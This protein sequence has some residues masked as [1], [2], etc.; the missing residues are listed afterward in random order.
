M[1]STPLVLLAHAAATLFMVGVIWFVQ[2]V[3]YPLFAK[4]GSD[5]F[6]PYAAAH[7]TLT[8]YIVGPPMVLEL[9][10]AVW[11]VA[12][13]P[14]GVNPLVPWV[15]LALVG[16]LWLSTFFVQVPLHESLRAAFQPEAWRRL[17]VT[18]LWRTALWT[19][20]GGLVLYV[21]WRAM[22]RAEC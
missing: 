5:A 21:L 15:G 10:T 11:L 18:N 3:H 9:L 17:V 19:V 13:P 16:A 1:F 22:T 7:G 4:V 6:V 8:G 20:R 14:P 2:V 12:H